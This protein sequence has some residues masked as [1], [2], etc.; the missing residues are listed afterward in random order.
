M[1]TTLTNFLEWTE[2]AAK[3][4]EKKKCHSVKGNW[5]SVVN[6][7]KRKIEETEKKGGGQKQKTKRNET[8]CEKVFAKCHIGKLF[9]FY[10]FY[11]VAH[12][13]TVH[14]CAEEENGGTQSKK[15]YNTGIEWTIFVMYN[16]AHFEME[17]LLWHETPKIEKVQNKVKPFCTLLLLHSL[18]DHK[19]KGK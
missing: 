10:F 15:M 14:L 5:R 8:K 1:T 11:Y 18:C 17:S 19:K 13:F 2:R 7:Y 4:E 9:E 12:I 16:V 6:K 3:D